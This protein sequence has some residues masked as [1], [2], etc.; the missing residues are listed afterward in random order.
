M[1]AATDANLR[2]GIQLALLA[3]EAAPQLAAMFQRGTTAADLQELLARDDAA[4]DSLQKAI[5]AQGADPTA[6]HPV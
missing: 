5:D 2:L 6:H 1:S 4:R 3:L